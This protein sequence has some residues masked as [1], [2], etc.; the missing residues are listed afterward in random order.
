MPSVTP[1][2]TEILEIER[3]TCRRT[4]SGDLSWITDECMDDV[5]QFSPGKALIAGKQEML[6]EF[7]KVLD[8]DGYELAW[9]PSKA[10]VSEANDMAYA[11]GTLT[12]KPPGG[13]PM[14]GKY[15]VVWVKDGDE[16]RLAIDIAN[17][18]A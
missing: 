1:D 5:L 3:E 13:E 2:P 10:V 18:D 14:P 4:R 7:R 6:A 8:T 12:M 9:E 17:L 16:W 11:Y 15:V